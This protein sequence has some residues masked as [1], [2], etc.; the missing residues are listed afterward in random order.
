MSEIPAPASRRPLRDRLL[1]RRKGAS[2]V[3]YAVLIGLIAVAVLGAVVLTGDRVRS[4]FGASEEAVGDGVA[5]LPLPETPGGGAGAG[6]PPPVPPGQGTWSGDGAFALTPQTTPEVRALTITNTG[7]GPLS[8]GA[9]AVGGTGAA[10]FEVLGSTCGPVLAPGEACEV[11]VQ[12]SAGANGSAVATLSLAGVSGGIALSL[13]ASGFDPALAWEPGAPVAIDGTAGTP[14]T[15]QTVFTL[16]NDGFADADISDLAVA[17]PGWSIVGTTCGAVLV[18]GATCSVTLQAQATDNGPLA[19]AILSAGGASTTATG[20]ASGFAPVLAWTG[21]PVFVLDGT[22]GAGP[23]PR[24]VEQAFT[25]TNAGT[26]A[27]TGLSVGISGAGFAAGLPPT[28]CTTTLAP[29]ESCTFT[30]QASAS[31]NGTFAGTLS[32]GG[33]TPATLPLS[34]EAS[35]FAPA[36]AFDGTG[37]LVFTVSN[38]PVLPA[39]TNQTAVLRNVGTLPGTVPADGISGPDAGNFARTGGTCAGQTLAPNATCTIQMTFTT[40]GPAGTRTATLSAGSAHRP[41]DGITSGTVP[42]GFWSGTPSFEINAPTVIATSQWQ[43]RTFTFTNTSAA[44]LT[45][46]AGRNLV[47]PLGIGS[48]TIQTTGTTCPAS[49]G[50]LAP[51]AS[52][53]TVV[54]YTGTNNG[55]GGMTLRLTATGGVQIDQPLAATV[56]NWGTPVFVLEPPAYTP[57]A[58][59]SPTTAVVTQDRNVYVRNIGLGAATGVVATVSG[60][61]F[62]LQWTN[63]TPTLG[64]NVAC[65]ITARYTTQNGQNGTFAGTAQL[66][67]SGGA[68]FSQA[69]SATVSGFVA[70]TWTTAATLPNGTAGAA[71]SVNL[72]ATDANNDLGTAPAATR[73][74]LVSGSPPPGLTLQ[75]VTGANLFVTLSGT[76]GATSGGSY[77][78][79]IRATDAS[80]QSADRT[81][82]LTVPTWT[83]TP[84]SSMVY[85]GWSSLT[86]TSIYRADFTFTNRT[87]TASAWPGVSSIT[88]TPP[89]TTDSVGYNGIFIEALS[90]CGSTVAPGGSCTFSIQTRIQIPGCD[91]SYGIRHRIFPNV[92]GLGP[93]DGPFVS[94]SGGPCDTGG[95]GDSGYDGGE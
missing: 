7:A 44:T 81:F 84:A 68:N 90:G 63:C 91:Q 6:G 83:V 50:T 70:P 29:G 55:T 8:L 26:L 46:V 36:W 66:T 20:A 43:E 57:H 89:F 80:G 47:S 72:T 64:S 12:A 42:A 15:G 53:T 93:V 24:T 82:T 18:Q 17:G 52:C 23:L 14:A 10:A 79:T 35:G 49:G 38:P 39:S 56:S 71:Y 87:A 48:F 40:Q 60:P 69:L 54:R 19:E 62:G 25:L 59:S 21:T 1:P 13:A 51:G 67:G 78:F 4:L 11:S 30:V 5:G 76:L 86:W 16:R 65:T 88:P 45:G 77:A 74:Q 33:A 61:G 75:P 22:P 37:S 28:T 95:G 85:L 94:D 41:M 31:D 34:A 2:Q 73:F 3:N 58:I 27:A 32:S 9:P 92:T